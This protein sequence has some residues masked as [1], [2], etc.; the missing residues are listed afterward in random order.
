MRY[1]EDRI[2]EV[3]M[4]LEP[5]FDPLALMGWLAKKTK[6]GDEPGPTPWYWTERFLADY[7]KAV[8]LPK[9]IDAFALVGVTDEVDAGVWLAEQAGQIP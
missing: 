8:D 7:D 4:R 1:D 3:L 9:V 6:Y 2:E 5:L